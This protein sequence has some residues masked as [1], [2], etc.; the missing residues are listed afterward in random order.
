MFTDKVEVTGD[1]EL[2]GAL[3]AGR[4]RAARRN[5][6]EPSS[7]MEAGTDNEPEEAE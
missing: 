4:A 5:A 7:G 3:N 1:E 6:E 2:I